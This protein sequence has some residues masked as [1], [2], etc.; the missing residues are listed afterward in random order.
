MTTQENKEEPDLSMSPVTK[1]FN[2]TNEE[3][4]T[5][6]S[7]FRLEDYALTKRIGQGSFGEVFLAL[8]PFGDKVVLKRIPKGNNFKRKHVER[9]ASV[10]TIL[11]GNDTI[12]ACK[13][14]FETSNNVYMMLNYFDGIDVIAWMEQRGFAP[15]SE[16]EAKKLFIQ[17]VEALL[18]C[19][20][21][22]VGHRDIKVK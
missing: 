2:N 22:G 10:G 11:S 20:N 7:N 17:I 16:K 1:F 21:K 3:D 18:Y 19:H 8:S 15:V 12:V 9:E 5:K 4:G 6:L 14:R 13:A